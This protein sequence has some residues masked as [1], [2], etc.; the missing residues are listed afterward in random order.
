VVKTKKGYFKSSAINLDKFCNREFRTSLNKFFKK[1]EGYS[2]GLISETIS[3]ALGKNERD[4]TLTKAGK[5]L[6]YILNKIEY[7]H[8]KKSI[9]K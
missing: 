5:I 3:S 7:N 2:F 4:G 8:C 9:D 1:K 6:V